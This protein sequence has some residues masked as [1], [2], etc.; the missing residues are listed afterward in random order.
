MV[1]NSIDT[2][3]IL[4]G[5]LGTRLRP[6]VPNVPK[7]MANVQGRPFLE[8]LLRL[9]QRQGIQHFVISVGY[10]ASAIQTHFGSSFLGSRIDYVFESSPLGTGG[11]LLACH[12]QFPQSAPFLL[13]NGDTYFDVDLQALNKHATQLEADWCLSVFRTSERAR[14]LL[15][16]MSTVD[17]L[18]YFSN[19]KRMLPSTEATFANG[20]VYWID[21]GSLSGITVS[22]FPA[23]LES[24]LLPCLESSGHRIIGFHSDGPFID[25]GLPLDFHRSQTLPFFSFI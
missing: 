19:L 7:P 12:T 8:H 2:A 20:G 4:A 22:S 17:S 6:V 10:M 18:I 13:L 3:F 9:W 11:A 21:P 15:L 5:G 25:I 1:T 14:F 16:G 24:E 23:S